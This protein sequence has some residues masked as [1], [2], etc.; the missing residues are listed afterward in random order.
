MATADYL[1]NA[2]SGVAAAVTTAAEGLAA[3]GATVDVVTPGL[4]GH[5]G[6]DGRLRIRPVHGGRFPFLAG[7]H[8]VVHLHS[9]PFAEM[10]FE[11]RRRYG[12]PVVYTAHSQLAAEL[13]GND[14]DARRWVDVQDLVME[15]SDMVVV[16]SESERRLAL[17][18]HP[19]LRHR[20]R[21]VPNA[22]APA[23]ATRPRTLPGSGAVVFAGRFTVTKGIDLMVA[24]ART[25]APRGVPFVF[26]GGHGNEEGDCMVAEVAAR[27]PDS[28]RMVGWLDR[29]GMLELMA[30]SSVVVI[31]SSYEPFG[32]VALEAMAAGTPVVAAGVGGLGE[33]VAAAGGRVMATRDPAVWSASV[34]EILASP[35]IAGEMRRRGR[36]HVARHHA[37]V[38]LARVLVRDVYVPAMAAA[39]RA[40]S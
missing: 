18:R 13:A 4:C 25:L 21:V 27:H 34:L 36:D 22:L 1:P 9:L 16:P 17:A 3:F 40:A 20:L 23:P 33:L 38:P 30:V 37:P 31:P 10:A 39:Q 32:M 14:G 2:W 35:E 28:C 29:R 5:A 19:G 8:D 6:G 15:A 12:T 7:D 24:I 26:A 11:M